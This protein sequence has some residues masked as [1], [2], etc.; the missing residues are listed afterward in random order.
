MGI[1]KSENYVDLTESAS[2]LWIEAGVKVPNSRVTNGPRV[3]LNKTAR[4]VAI[5]TVAV[6]GQRLENYPVITKCVEQSYSWD[7]FATLAMTDIRR[8]Y[9]IT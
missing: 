2:G 3:G 7:C 1:T 4:T 5:Q 9:G 6:F 8:H